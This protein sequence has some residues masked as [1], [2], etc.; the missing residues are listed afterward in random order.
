MAPVT[1]TGHDVGVNYRGIR[2]WKCR[3]CE[4]W[5]PWTK[6][7][8][9]II[10]HKNYIDVTM[11]GSPSRQLLTEVVTEFMCDDCDLKF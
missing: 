9:D 6:E 8:P 4:K 3:S 10:T 2:V 5:I 11:Y 7:I 1:Q